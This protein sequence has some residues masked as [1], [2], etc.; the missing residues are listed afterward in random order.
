VV[1]VTEKVGVWTHAKKGEKVIGVAKAD[2]ES[3]ASVT[4]DLEDPVGEDDRTS[5]DV[6]VG[7]QASVSENEGVYE[8][9]VNVV[10]WEE[11]AID[12]VEEGWVI[13]D[14]GMSD[15]CSV[16]EQEIESYAM[17]HRMDR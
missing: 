8:E 9:S 12:V 17:G 11:S 4:V 10:V 13:V 6:E 14:G 7:P 2:V 15:N 1:C 16:L 3:I 5:Q